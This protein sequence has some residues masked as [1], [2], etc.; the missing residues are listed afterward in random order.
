METALYL[1]ACLCFDRCCAWT[2]II[3][4]VQ[5]VEPSWYSNFFLYELYFAETYNPSW[6]TRLYFKFRKAYFLTEPIMGGEILSLRPVRGTVSNFS[7]SWH[8]CTKRTFSCQKTHLPCHEEQRGG[9]FVGF[10]QHIS[11]VK[12]HISQRQCANRGR[13]NA[14]AC[15]RNSWTAWGEY[16]MC[17]IIFSL[18]QCKWLVK[19]TLWTC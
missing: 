12:S 2:A 15:K 18:L 7:L 3:F 16:K 13:R 9:G 17:S 10:G 14:R 1:F 5:K 4:F 11:E 19:E 6:K 8:P